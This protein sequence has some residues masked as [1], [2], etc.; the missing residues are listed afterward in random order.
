MLGI[1]PPSP[2]I[3][4][5]MLPLGQSSGPKAPAFSGLILFKEIGSSLLP[6]LASR[7]WEIMPACISRGEKKQIEKRCQESGR[8]AF[9]DWEGTE[10][11]CSRLGL[12]LSRDSPTAS[13]ATDPSVHPLQETASPTRHRTRFKEEGRFRG[14]RG[15]EE[16]S[17]STHMQ[18][19]K[20]LLLRPRLWGVQRCSRRS[21]HVPADTA[22]T[23]GQPSCVD[24]PRCPR[25]S[26]TGRKIHHLCG[27]VV[28]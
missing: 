25:H 23:C 7:S 10:Q 3:T 27:R 28:P 11:S 19:S 9:T 14:S 17:P 13:F 8:N 22:C 20:H 26:P 12:Q 18:S 21:Q 24:P 4:L 1:P 16:P 6:S 5:G 2:V 15:T